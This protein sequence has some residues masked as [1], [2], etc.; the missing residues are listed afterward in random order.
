MRVYGPYL[1]KDGRQHVIVIT[2]SN[3]RTVS[4]PKFLMEQKLGRQLDPDLETVDHIDGDFTNNNFSNLRI[5]SRSQHTKED[6]VRAVS[7][8][9]AC[10]WCG[11]TLRR[12][13]RHV[14]QNATAGKAGPFCRPC[15][16]KYGTDI[17]NRR[18]IPLAPQP[19]VPLLY[20]K[21]PK[22]L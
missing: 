1:R 13:R 7:I 16:G 21:T 5:I 19:S 4:Y 14:N 9:Q 11:C 18:R 17:Q 6:A 2:G 10:V 12:Q 3:R 15:A 22:R 20:A 8:T